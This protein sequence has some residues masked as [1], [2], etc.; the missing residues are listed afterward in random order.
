[1]KNKFY[2]LLICLSVSISSIASD[3]CPNCC[4]GY[5]GISYGDS[6][7]GRFVCN[8]GYVSQCYSTRHAIMNLQK[9]KGCCMW[10]GGVLK[11]TLKGEV[12]CR[13]GQISELCSAAYQQ[14]SAVVF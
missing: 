11:V 2:F 6:S 5:G 13:D 14:A 9:F 3:N 12:I 1:M 10:E 7:S 4:V 8:N